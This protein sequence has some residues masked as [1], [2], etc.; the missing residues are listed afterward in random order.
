MSL[1]EVKNISKFYGE[2]QVLKDISINI[3]KEKFM[4]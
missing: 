4:A 2:N 3:K 1:L